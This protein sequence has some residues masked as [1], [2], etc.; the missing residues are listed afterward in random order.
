[1]RITREGTREMQNLFLDEKIERAI[2][3][4]KEYEPP[5][6]YFVAFSGGKDSIVMYDIVKKSGVKYEVHYHVTTIDPPELL[7]FI[8]QYYSEVIWDLPKRNM[9]QLIDYHHTLPTRLFR[10]CCADL[11]EYHG[12]GRVIVDGIRAEESSRRAR[13]QMIEQDE[14]RGKMFIHIIF[15]WSEKEVWEYIRSHN[16]PYCELYDE[17]YK[18]IGCI[19]CPMKNKKEREK[20][21][22]RY[23]YLLKGYKNA[24]RKHFNKKPNKYFGTNVDEYFEWWMS[25]LSI[26]KF[27]EKKK[28]ESG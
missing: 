8:K 21:F 25:G 16:M 3:L 5:E 15:D 13:R 22:K 7:K 20:D 18:R 4:L 28:K 27:F 14:K 10:F 11:K 23:P 2:K 6:G 9:F 19:A 26:K 24:L 1:M 17:G 12:K